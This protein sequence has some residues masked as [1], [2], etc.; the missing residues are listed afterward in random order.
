MA[1]KRKTPLTKQEKARFGKTGMGGSKKK[2]KSKKQAP[3]G[4]FIALLSYCQG[5]KRQDLRTGT[6]Q[7]KK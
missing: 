7:Y 5:I 3:S 2:R 4:V 1:T 6:D